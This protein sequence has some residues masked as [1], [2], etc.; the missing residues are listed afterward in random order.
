MNPIT[1]PSKSQEYRPMNISNDEVWQ[2]GYYLLEYLRL[3]NRYHDY[4]MLLKCVPEKLQ[5]R[6]KEVIRLQ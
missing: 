3:G 5:K 1:P 2:M 6:A 4:E